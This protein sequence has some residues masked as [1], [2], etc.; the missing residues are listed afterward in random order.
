M[1][2]DTA[3]A[4]GED[5]IQHK[6]SAEAQ[7]LAGL[8]GNFA[9]GMQQRLDR[10]VQNPQET[11]MQAGCFAAVGCAV[12]LITKNPAMF[13]E[14]AAPYIVS[15]TKI[16]PKALLTIAGADLA[17]QV[18]VPAYQTW[19]DPASLGLMQKKLG[20]NLA[21]TTFD[22]AFVG[23]AGGVGSKL[24]GP[25]ARE[26]ELT[27]RALQPQLRMATEGAQLNPGKSFSNEKSTEDFVLRA[28]SF[29]RGE[30]PQSIRLSGNLHGSRELPSRLYKPG[31][32]AFYVQ[33]ANRGDKGAAAV[34]FI[35]DVFTGRSDWS[36]WRPLDLYNNRKM[37]KPL[38]F[39]L[40][41][42]DMGRKIPFLRE[43][44][45]KETG[46]QFTW[47]ENGYRTPARLLLP[48]DYPRMPLQQI[49]LTNDIQS[50]VERPGKYSK[51]DIPSIGDTWIRYNITD[52]SPSGH[53]GFISVLVNNAE[54]WSKTNLKG[55]AKT[56]LEF[57]SIKEADK[58]A[59]GIEQ[60][61]RE[62][63]IILT[64]YMQYD[65]PVYYFN[66]R[67]FR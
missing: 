13:G 10:A 67:K 54:A 34:R 36:A 7:L 37:L 32:V 45:Q 18:G 60:K 6:L 23:T 11:A 47:T 19:N 39:G 25:I 50:G 66:F 62:R 64:P 22:L 8:P 38:F 31:D 14:A 9:G 63:P 12:G 57:S 20:Q 46:T 2:R 16:L 58:F 49:R 40:N 56:K 65:T 44:I 61:L 3:K 55:L 28:Q 48:K 27:S 24:A 59:A 51:S 5:S 4:T 15:A 17:A 53:S 43:L 26:L 42:P 33:D 52:R 41:E 30:A 1:E 21:D 35:L 29:N